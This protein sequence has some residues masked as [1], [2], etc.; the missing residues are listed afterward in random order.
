MTVAGDIGAAAGFALTVLLVL[1]ARARRRSSNPS[2]PREPARRRDR[3]EAF[4]D[5][6]A[7]VHSWWLMVL[8]FF[9]LAAVGYLFLTD[10]LARA[11]ILGTGAV[12]LVIV[13]IA[14]S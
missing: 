14:L 13:T 2:L 9:V 1:R 3:I 11:I 8:E 5:A 12:C 4:V 6:V 7:R 10:A